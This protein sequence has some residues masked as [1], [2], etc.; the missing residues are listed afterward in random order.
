MA[1]LALSA[2]FAFTFFDGAFLAMGAAFV[3][4]FAAESGAVAA[5]GVLTLASLVA[6]GA[7]AKEAAA[8]LEKTID[9]EPRGADYGSNLN[10]RQA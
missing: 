4:D 5:T 7:C 1:D 8:T 6:A 10:T 9:T 2:F 3:S